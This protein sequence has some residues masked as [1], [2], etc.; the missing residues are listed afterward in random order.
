MGTLNYKKTN[1]K[2]F[3]G[4]TYDRFKIAEF[5]T[6]NLVNT[7]NPKVVAI[8]PEKEDLKPDLNVLDCE[9][10]EVLG[11]I[12]VQGVSNFSSKWDYRYGD[13]QLHGRRLEKNYDRPTLFVAYDINTD[14]YLLCSLDRLKTAAKTPLRTEY[15][16][17]VVDGLTVQM[18]EKILYLPLD[19]FR[20]NMGLDAVYE[21][22]KHKQNVDR[23]PSRKD[24][25]FDFLK[26]IKW[27]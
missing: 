14:S 26:D 1:H 19:I 5:L 20:K 17:R 2:S 8:V 21:W 13:F 10:R 18:Q 27:V 4:K 24:T 25:S 23:E 9:T 11:Y 6:A 3:S 22:M 16:D 7:L 12:E 15:V